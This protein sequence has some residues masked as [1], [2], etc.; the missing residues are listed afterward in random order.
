MWTLNQIPF[1]KLET[2]PEDVS[3]LLNFHEES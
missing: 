1:I 3:L 2:L